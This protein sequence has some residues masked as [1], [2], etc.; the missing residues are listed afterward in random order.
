MRDMPIV[1]ELFVC[2]GDCNGHMSRHF[3]GVHG[4]YGENQ[5]NL[6]GY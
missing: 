2:F 6:E 1:D 5:R 3:V 4:G